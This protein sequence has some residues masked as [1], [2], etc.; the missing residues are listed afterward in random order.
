M[1]YIVHTVSASN[2]D[3]SSTGPPIVGIGASAGG[4]DALQQFFETVSPHLGV[5]YVVIMHLSPDFESHLAEILGRSTSMPVVQVNDE[6]EILP[7]HVYVIPPG[8]QL[9]TADGHLRSEPFDNPGARRAA[10]DTFFRSLA[11]RGDAS[12]VIVMSGG[13]SDGALGAKAIKEQ[14]GVV[15]VQDPAEAAHGSMPRAVMS[16]GLADVVLPSARLAERLAE[17]VQFTRQVSPERF[18]SQ[19]D[20]LLEEEEAA[21]GD[22]LKLL[23]VHSGN[24]FAGYK[25]ATVLRRLSRRMQ[26]NQVS[27]LKD[28]LALLTDNE[29]ELQALFED[30][31]ITVTRFFRDP[32]CWKAL[33]RE[34]ITKIVTQG[35]ANDPIRIWT[36]GCATGE[37]AYSVAMLVS[38]CLRREKVSRDLTVFATDVDEKAINVARHGRYPAGIIA[39]VTAARLKRYFHTEDDNYVVSEAIR[40]R[41]I[42]AVHNLFQDPPFRH[43]DLIICRNLLIYVNAPLQRQAQQVFRY[44]LRQS[45]GYLFTGPAE[46]ANRE[47]FE[48]LDQKCRIYKTTPKMVLS[49]PELGQWSR[50]PRAGAAA[51]RPGPLSHLAALEAL[52]PPSILIDDEGKIINLSGSAGRF[53]ELPGGALASRA[54]Q[55]VRPE[56]KNI[57]SAA[58]KNAFKRRAKTS[59][60]FVRVRI[61][62]GETEVALL[63]HPHEGKDEEQ[64]AL[65]MFLERHSGPPETGAEPIADG[66]ESEDEWQADDEHLHEDLEAANE[67]LQSLNEEYR[68]T[69]EE[70]E[71]SKEELQSVNEELQTVNDQ[72]K[73]KLSEISEAHDDLENLMA[74]TEVGTLFLDRDLHIKRFTP[75]LTQLYNITPADIGRP[76]GNFTHRLDYDGLQ[77]DAQRVLEAL[78]PIERYAK[79]G[80]GLVLIV[81]LRPYR[82]R[83]DRI[84][85]VVITFMDITRQKA[86]EDALQVSENRLAEELQTM[87]RLHTMTVDMT[88]ADSFEQS[89]GAL[90]RAALDLHQCDFGTIHLANLERKQ[91]ELTASQ[92]LPPNLA[93]QQRVIRLDDGG[94]WSH[95]LQTREA[96]TITDLTEEAASG[97]QRLVAGKGD[98]QAFRATPLISGDDKSVGVLCCYCVKPRGWTPRDEQTDALLART[99]ADLIDRRFQEEKLAA[100]VVK[101]RR[102]AQE[103]EASQAELRRYAAAV[104]KRD[105]RNVEFLGLLGHELRNP[106][107]AVRNSLELLSMIDAGAGEGDKGLRESA[108]AILHRQAAHMSRL[109]NDILD[110][111]RLNHGKFELQMQPTNIDEAVSHVVTVWRPRFEQKKLE[112]KVSM[113]E[114]PLILQADPDRLEQ[115]LENLLSNAHKYTEAGGKVEVAAEV[116]GDDVLISVIDSGI[117]IAAEDLDSVFD[118]Y[119]QATNRK[120]G[121]L[122]LGLSLTKSLVDLHGGGI[123]ACSD[124]PGKGSKFTLRMP[125]ARQTPLPPPPPLELT[126]HWRILVVDDQRDVA[127][128]L[129][130]LLA[131]LGN[132]TRVAYTGQD[133]LRAAE[134][135][136][137]EIAF[138][139]LSMPNMGGAEI[140]ERLRD[141]A[142][143]DTLTFIGITG[144]AAADAEESGA[145]DRC[146]SKPATLDSLRSLLKSLE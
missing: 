117:G 7:D 131:S 33:D 35:R 134:A 31:L 70:L 91:L 44:A 130:R 71:T 27:S 99:A 76:I 39:D 37:E 30:L 19:P 88:R 4:I 121:G 142:D 92:G 77:Q 103:L 57:L 114:Q 116:E 123:R 138:L 104:R 122:G 21:V 95:V 5:A 110:I 61:N 87:R 11:S 141:N 143:D 2:F 81:R 13:D 16:A 48:T 105:E 109:I 49:L 89:L 82:T 50:R 6:P 17:F 75:M 112:L 107:A 84:E 28:Y 98:Y 42:F 108:L 125:L 23:Q 139:D 20:A 1:R 124:G 65:V 26:I 100:T 90:L 145:F 64:A 85:G 59:T 74:A 25:R 22:I 146:I 38:D 73:K 118:P 120:D 62:G 58:I 101:L 102:Q 140:A 8:R 63:V 29:P 67:E 97:Q 128:S 144:H 119:R 136:L 52:A 14:G 51:A 113:P 12:H 9:K 15:L 53:L 69:A 40:D 32:D 80:D 86:V 3:K 115:I 93:E 79:T 127:D 83:E 96:L 135:F 34:A 94:P 54:V 45:H 72:L 41:V 137:P 24:D 129:A 111:T 60:G 55:L 47:W 106:L 66:E 56:L 78:A 132:E 126:R 10:I 68:A 46:V 36:A 18:V 133:A 43:L